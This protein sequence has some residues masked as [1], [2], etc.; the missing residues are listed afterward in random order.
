[1]AARK[2]SRQ[3]DTAEIARLVKESLAEGSAVEIEGLGR[4][5]R[6]PTG[7][8]RFQPETRPQVFIAY[9]VEDRT[10]ASKLFQALRKSGYDPWMDC[11]KLLPG[12]NWPRAIERAI[13]NSAY[14]IACLTRRSVVKPGMFQAELRY[15][16]ECSKRQ[17][18]GD[19]FLIPVRLDNCK[20]PLEIQRE[21][22][23][24]DLFPSWEKGLARIK[25]VMDEEGKRPKAA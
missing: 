17:P 3:A 11:E 20:V 21:I 15:A 22:Q 7:K 24:I 13:E 19:I 10:K 12:Q 18:L 5:S 6:D 16:L 23:Y 9:A 14:F 8:W 25:N 2:S 4:F 1:M